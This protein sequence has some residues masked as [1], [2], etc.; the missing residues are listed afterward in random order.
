MYGLDG[1][2]QGG[3][4][5]QTEPAGMPSEQLQAGATLQDTYQVVGLIGR[6]G[7][8]EVYEVLHARLAGRYALKLLSAEA[9]KDGEAFL[10]FRREAEIASSLRHP[11][12]VQVIDFDHTPDGRPYLVM[13]ML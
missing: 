2:L 8:G 3:H 12:I 9:E 13:E 11:H 10:R 1:P 4:N 5:G 6:G 7:M